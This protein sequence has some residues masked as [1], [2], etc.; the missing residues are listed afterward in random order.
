MPAAKIAV[1]LGGSS[2]SVSEAWPS[3]PDARKD[4][5]RLERKLR[6]NGFC[7]LSDP[8]ASSAQ[9]QLTV[10][11]AAEQ[12]DVDTEIVLIHWVGHGAQFGQNPVLIPIGAHMPDGSDATML[13]DVLNQL[14]G[15]ASLS[16]LFIVTLDCCLGSNVFATDGALPADRNFIIMYTCRAADDARES[17]M[18]AVSAHGCLT[19]AFLHFGFE[20]SSF[21]DVVKNMKVAIGTKTHGA[22]EPWL[23]SA[24]M[25][26]VSQAQ[27]NPLLW[28]TQQLRVERSRIEALQAQLREQNPRSEADVAD[29]LHENNLSLRSELTAAKLQLEWTNGLLD[30]EDKR[31]AHLQDRI[32][33][34][35]IFKAAQTGLSNFELDRIEQSPGIEEVRTMR[36]ELQSK[37]RE[38]QEMQ[39]NLK[40]EESRSAQLQRQMDT[41]LF[42]LQEALE[43]EKLKNIE[44]S[45]LIESH[46]EGRN[47]LEGSLDRIQN[48]KV[49][50]DDDKLRRDADHLHE[51]EVTRVALDEERSRNTELED[52]QIDF[53][54][55]KESVVEEQ[56][57]SAK[58]LIELAQERGKTTLAQEGALITKSQPQ[59]EVSS[60]QAS[61]AQLELQRQKI[62]ELE[63]EGVESGTLAAAK[64][65]DFAKERANLA[66][67]EAQCSDLRAKLLQDVESRQEL[68]TNLRVV[69]MVR[70]EIANRCTAYKQDLVSLQVSAMKR[71]Q[72]LLSRQE[73]LAELARTAEGQ[74]LSQSVDHDSP[75]PTIL[76]GNCPPLSL[77]TETYQQCLPQR[78]VSPLSEDFGNLQVERPLPSSA[79]LLSQQELEQMW[80]DRNPPA[81]PGTSPPV[82]AEMSLVSNDRMA[83]FKEKLAQKVFRQ[84][85]QFSSVGLD[86]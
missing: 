53:E 38:L 12:I 73:K 68:E 19:Q 36:A 44:L 23:T 46:H 55:L 45:A 78:E 51:L 59:L 65:A 61:Y 43:K 17:P 28:S 47:A 33:E 69:D 63:G 24:S 66:D 39:E 37:T 71:E 48:L 86:S 56:R 83:A 60:L 1:L 81:V 58:L 41:A 35:E 15:H 6:R 4:V 70:R 40:E 16:T 42:D 25:E 13:E 72:E 27:C 26:L 14:C 5:Q 85:I 8:D 79:S 77:A 82:M 64:E 21:A 30:V 50:L 49:A 54:L 34:L 32:R 31:N 62:M 11:S 18:D 29:Q 20:D 57:R 3:L 75:L 2:Y 9:I 52:K 80:L 22:L 10:N 74:E 67:A 7:V 84:E 76:T